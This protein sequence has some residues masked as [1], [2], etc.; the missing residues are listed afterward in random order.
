MNSRLEAYKILSKVMVKNVYSDKL[1][2][3]VKKNHTS[4][5]S[6]V[7]YVYLFVKGVIK[8]RIQFLFILSHFMEAAKLDKTDEKI[9]ILLYLGLYQLLYVDSIPPHAAINETVELAKALF[10]GKVANFIN[11]IL[12]EYL[13]NPSILYPENVS[14]RLSN[15]YSFPKE[16]IEK[17]IQLW[18][19]ETTEYLCLYFNEN[20]KLS[21]R[22]NQIAT[23]P[24]KLMEYFHRRNVVLE[25]SELTP[26]VLQTTHAS[27][28]LNDVAFSEGYFSIQD[29]SAALVV[30][31]M[32]LQPKDVV[33]DLFAAPGGKTSYIA[34]SIHDNGEVFA[35]D[36]IPARIKLLKQNVNRLQ[37]TS[38]KE[39]CQDA[40]QFGP[41]A[42]SFDKVLLDVPCS[43]WGVMQKKAELRWQYHQ[44]MADILKLQAKALKQGSLFVKE[45]GFLIYSTCTLNPEENEEQVNL[46]LS[47]HKEFK[48]VAADKAL[49]S[50]FVKNGFLHIMPFQ[51][52][53]DGV[54]AAKMQRIIHS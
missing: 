30:E 40:F 22:V 9:K 42:P 18:G 35:V 32:G 16:L 12:R 19:E 28:V 24:D 53:S 23:N 6:E 26:M 49:N 25:K 4:S 46:F 13:R 39:F 43:G 17:W 27:A 36:K 5:F 41:V 1:L 33:L 44:D 50:S 20:P 54:F 7:E 34:E 51:H 14:D 31:L 8:F 37:L 15:Q 21:I 3:Q 45:G 52:N 38:V 47:K 2:Q 11:A 29:A 48:L 10:D